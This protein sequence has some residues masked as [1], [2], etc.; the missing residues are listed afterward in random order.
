MPLIY[1]DNFQSQFQ[2]KYLL[3]RLYLLLLISVVLHAAI[4]LYRLALKWGFFEGKNPK[5]S[6]LVMKKIMLVSVVVYLTIGLLSLGTY[7]MIG[8]KH[9]EQAGERYQPSV[10]K[11]TSAG[12]LKGQK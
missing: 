6:R 7:T 8:Y 3:Q 2:L 5:K 9:S 11:Q 1:L 12:I 10:L 4:G